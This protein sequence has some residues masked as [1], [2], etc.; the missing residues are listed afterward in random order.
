MTPAAFGCP[1]FPACP[2]CPWVGRPYADQLASKH[3]RVVAALAATLPDLAS[4]VVTSVL[5]ALEPSG[6]RVQTK[7]MVGGTR[8]L[9]LGLYAPGSHR[10]VDASGCP[11]HHP[12]LQRA[13]PAIRDA[14]AD[15]AVPLHGRGRTGVRYVLVRA[16]LA[17]ERV[18]VT[19]VSSRTPLPHAERLARRLRTAVPLA[20]L[21][22]NENTTTRQRDP[23][24]AHGVP[25]GRGGAPRALR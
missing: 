4:D 24:P 1:H 10:V 2:G 20:G 13:I 16:S 6:Y 3:R 12:L 22:L 15:D 8:R 14:L 9:V 21:L 17:E 5:P 7:L 11:L 23:R 18:L 25:V 19:L